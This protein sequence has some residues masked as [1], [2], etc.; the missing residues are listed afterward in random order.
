MGTLYYLSNIHDAVAPIVM[1]TI[2][3][4]KKTT[5]LEHI[6]GHT[7]YRTQEPCFSYGST[8]IIL[9]GCDWKL[10]GHR[11]SHSRLCLLIIFIDGRR[12][13]KFI[14][15]SEGKYNYGWQLETSTTV[16]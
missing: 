10:Y 6:Q 1:D 9:G 7:P 4:R 5:M 3:Q 12:R 16:S 14:K 15:V 2:R 13:A 11:W 8:E